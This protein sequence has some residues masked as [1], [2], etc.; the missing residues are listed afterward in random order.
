MAQAQ[1]PS[2]ESFLNVAS[3]ADVTLVPECKKN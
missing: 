2:E 1:I 3:D